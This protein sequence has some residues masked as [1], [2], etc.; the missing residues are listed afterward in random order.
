MVGIVFSEVDPIRREG[1]LLR[2]PVAMALM[3]LTGETIA[4]GED[5][6]ADSCPSEV[7]FGRK[8]VLAQARGG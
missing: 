7:T 5:Q 6:M 1:M 8:H 4:L 3:N 2:K